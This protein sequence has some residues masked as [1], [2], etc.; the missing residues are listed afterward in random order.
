LYD[1]LVERAAA[2]ERSVGL[3]DGAFCNRARPWL[4]F[5]LGPLTWHVDHR[6]G[7]AALYAATLVFWLYLTI[8]AVL[9]AIFPPT[10]GANMSALAI[11]I[12][13]AATLVAGAV[14]WLVRFQRRACECTLRRNVHAAMDMLAA[15][16]NEL[17]RLKD[18]PDFLKACAAA[19]DDKEA[20]V[21][22]RAMFYWS[23][24]PEEFGYYVIAGSKLQTT[25]SIVSLLTDLSPLWAFDMASNRRGTQRP[26]DAHTP[27]NSS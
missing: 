20:T 13:A 10:S 14:W 2:I 16:D 25:A 5:G 1:G 26:G 22:A 9:R 27:A 15:H 17:C 23:L 3:P 7:V 24:N 4:H 11:P 21:A 18:N 6:Q 12:L 19:L 8:E